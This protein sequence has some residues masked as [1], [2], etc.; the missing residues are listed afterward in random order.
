MQNDYLVGK[1]SF[2]G[3][4]IEGNIHLIISK[5]NKDVIPFLVKMLKDVYESKNVYI[6]F[7]LANGDNNGIFPDK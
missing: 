7:K 2:I 5:N 3:L 1:L 4:D 6:N